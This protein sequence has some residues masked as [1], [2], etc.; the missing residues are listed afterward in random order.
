MSWWL[1]LYIGVVVVFT[2]FIILALQRSSQGRLVGRKGAHARV[3][4]PQLTH[5]CCRG[6]GRRIPRSGPR[7][8][9]PPA[10]R[11]SARQ[12]P[13]RGPARPG[14][15]ADALAAR[16]ITLTS[17]LRAMDADGPPEAGR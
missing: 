5:R 3:T 12:H 4:G 14:L 16:G 9:V 13:G 2:I 15:L 17:V 11:G 8:P 1:W 10:G 7:T 6:S